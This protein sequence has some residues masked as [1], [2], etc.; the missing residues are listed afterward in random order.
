MAAIETNGCGLTPKNLNLLQEAGVYA[1]WLD[2]KAFDERVHIW[3]AGY[4]NPWIIKLPGEILQRGFVL[5]VLSL[6]IS[7]LVEMD[8]LSRI[9]ELLASTSDDIPST[10]L[11]FFPEYGMGTF[12]PPSTEEMLEAYAVA[13]AT[14]LKNVRLGN[15]GVFAR[16]QAEMEHVLKELPVL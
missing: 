3:L 7:G 13:M 6:Y 16:T 14:G 10:I 8:Q 1:F 11:A 12:R 2:I 15:I 4:T 9:A 5:E